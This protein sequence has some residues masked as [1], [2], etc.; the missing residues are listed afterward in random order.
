[1]NSEKENAVTYDDFTDQAVVLISDEAHHMNAW[2]KRGKKTKEESEHIQNWEQTIAN[3]FNKDNG[4]LPNILLEFT[5]TADFSHPAIAQKYENKV[6]FNY[7]LKKFREDLYSKDVEVLESDLEPLDMALQAMILSQYK[8]KIFAE[9]KQDI[10]PVL[11]LKSKTIP[12][13]KD[14]Y[15]IFISAV[16]NLDEAGIE[17]IRQ[18]AKDDLLAAFSYFDKQGITASNLILELQEDLQRSVFYL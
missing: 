12:A 2:T 7:Q 5:A 1:M 14:I 13:N 4:T 16:A 3:I 8:R 17:R 9:I 10:K 18:R 6:I 11:L 15:T